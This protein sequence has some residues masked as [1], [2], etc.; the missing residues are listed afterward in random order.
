MTTK[1]PR[2]FPSSPKQQPRHTDSLSS[3][4]AKPK[5]TSPI[6]QSAD[7]AKAARA[8]LETPLSTLKEE[9]RLGQEERERKREEREGEVGGYVGK[10]DWEGGG[11]GQPINPSR[12][13]LNRPRNSPHPNTLKSPARPCQ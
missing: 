12:Q 13:E 6:I 5:P 2:T 9:D 1:L 11:A 4:I 3:S 7:D 8:L 10:N